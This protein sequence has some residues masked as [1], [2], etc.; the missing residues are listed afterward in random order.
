M[1]FPAGGS[2][3]QVVVVP[4]F[5]LPVALQVRL[6]PERFLPASVRVSLECT[7]GAPK[8]GIGG[9]GSSALWVLQPV[10]LL[11]AFGTQ[12]G[13]SHSELS[14]P[15]AMLDVLLS[16]PASGLAFQIVLFSG[17]GLPEAVVVRLC[18]LSLGLGRSV[19][20]FS[21]CPTPLV[22]GAPKRGIGGSGSSAPSLTCLAD[23]RFISSLPLV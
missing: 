11:Y 4:G 1:S 7:K 8:R 22:L 16:F 3:L 18:P 21:W 20:I 9:S 6:C 17:V 15:P 19:S 5:W 23:A 14:L 2:Y 10:A 13:S 12:L